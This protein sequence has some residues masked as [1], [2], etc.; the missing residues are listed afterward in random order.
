MSESLANCRAWRRIAILLA[1]A[2]VALTLGLGVAIRS[3]AQT[4]PPRDLTQF[5]L[6]DLMNVQ[7]ISVSKKEQK[8]A[9]TGAAIF[10]ITQ[11][12]I[13]R[14]GAT[15]IPDLLRMVPGVNVARVDHSTWAVSVRGFND[16]YANKVLVLIDGRS[17]YH[18][19]FSGVIWFAQ[20]M[21]LENIERIEVIRGPGGTVWGANAMN[22]VINIITKSAKDTP[23]G[24]IRAGGG[25]NSQTDGLVQ[26]G[27]KIG[28]TGNYRVYG[29]YANLGKSDAAT[30]A[31]PADSK[32][33]QE[34]GFRSDWNL[35]SRDLLTVQGEVRVV[36][37]GQTIT[38]VILGVPPVT[39]TFGQ[40]STDDDGNLLAR[41]THRFLNGWDM[42]VQA[43]YDQSHVF[44]FGPNNWATIGNVDFQHHLRIASRNDVVWGLSY[45]ANANRF[46]GSSLVTLHPL[47]R[48]DSLYGAFVQDEITLTRTLSLTLGSK[49]EHNN[50]TGF[51][52][53]PSAQLVWAPSARHTIWASA[54]KAIRQPSNIDSGLEII[55][56]VQPL[57]Q[58]RYG[59]VTVSGN[60]N[61]KVEQLRDYETGYRAQ[62]SRR[63]SL[64]V[65][66]FLGFY[67]NLQTTEPRTPYF[68]TAGG[69]LVIPLVFDYKAH[70]V[71][72]GAEAFATWNV[73]DRWKI[74]P[75]LS[76]LK[77]SVRRDA[78]SQDSTIEQTPGRSPQRS[79][80]TRSFINL[81]RNFEWDQTLGYTG[82][83]AA[84][85]IPG[86]VRL[87]TRF[88]WRW[89]ESCDFSLVGQNLLAPRH[90]EFPDIHF[91]D[92][93][94]DQRSVF[95]KITW[96]F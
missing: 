13:R 79:F 6:E 83:L 8:L 38:G 34:G 81:G 10:V 35:T 89:G 61:T 11:E 48:T 67:H 22:G 94:Q 84:G 90:A 15:S 49:F 32:R 12:D 91:V 45:R 87:D 16:N 31:Q 44:A 53:E 54:A 46:S 29:R 24:L 86:Y 63:L 50:Y 96:R 19:V 58:G 3:S 68:N 59:L 77:M 28:Q 95:G 40:P 30:F 64:D 71:S 55:S 5:T 78:S 66:G 85:N 39:A 80:Q 14:S 9:K 51:E 76:M 60:P 18:P 26:Y 7:V 52:I 82:P 36:D 56:A 65:A 37:G 27:G 21:P 17:V 1:R 75:G 43:Y 92:H 42:S 41:W 93:M 62:I 4:P 33:T 70:A 23:G 88:G 72:Y 2:G 47:E 20:E 74:S 69:Y 57:G 25:S 73:T